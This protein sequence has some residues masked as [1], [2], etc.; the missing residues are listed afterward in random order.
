MAL[1]L[2]EDKKPVPDIIDLLNHKL[3]WEGY[4]YCLTEYSD[5][6]EIEPVDPELYAMIVAFRTGNRRNNAKGKSVREYLKEKYG[7][8]RAPSPIEMS[9]NM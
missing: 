6:R 2:Q 7:L 9:R 1:D 4:G 5:W 8:E 3:S